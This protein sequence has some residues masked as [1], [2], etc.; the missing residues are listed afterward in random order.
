MMRKTY[1]RLFFLILIVSISFLLFASSRRAAADCTT[2]DDSGKCDQKKAQTE[3]ILW[4][5]LSRNL[6][7][8]NH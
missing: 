8:V 7:S 5:S 2:G 6:L 3:F 4:E 1:I